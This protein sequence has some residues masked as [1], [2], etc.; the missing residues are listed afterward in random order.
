MP[1]KPADFHYYDWDFNDWFGSETRA[2]CRSLPNDY[3]MGLL[4]NAAEGAY[5][6]L[7]DYCYKEGDIPSDLGGLAALCGLDAEIFKLVWPAF[8]S[9]FSAHKKEP[10]RLVNDQVSLRRKTFLQKRKISSQNGRAGAQKRGFVTSK[11]INNIGSLAKATIKPGV[12]NQYS[13]IS[14]QYIEEQ[15]V[16]E[17][18][19]YAPS[20]KPTEE[21]FNYES[22]FEEL[23]KLW[24]GKG[25]TKIVDS[26]RFYVETISPDP[27]RLH[28]SLAAPVRPG[29]KWAESENWKRGFV[30]SI[31][32]YIRNRRDLED[33]ERYDPNKTEHKNGRAS[34]YESAK[35][36][37]EEVDLSDVETAY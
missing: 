29:G 5:R 16:K 21:E 3:P 30:C 20:Q 23:W 33:P 25:R 10:S 26:Q 11:E 1:R 22:G 4:A 31:S 15:E 17:E 8:R 36:S 24:P 18:P 14:K 28:E 7:L 19:D 27:P 13:V 12:P 32:E 35:K 34:S 37:I 2:R 6:N 9:K